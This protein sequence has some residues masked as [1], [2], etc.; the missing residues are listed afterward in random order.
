MYRL[1]RAADSRS[2]VR[3]S[4]TP[5]PAS[6]RGIGIDVPTYDEA[7][8]TNLIR[9]VVGISMGKEYSTV[10]PKYIPIPAFH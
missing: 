9:Y 8:M 2:L 7:F 1:L 6:M 3:I 5:I 10:V 4:S